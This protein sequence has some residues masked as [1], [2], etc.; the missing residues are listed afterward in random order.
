MASRLLFVD[1]EDQYF[2]THRLAPARAA[3]ARGYEVHVAT[4]LG[5]G[6]DAIEAEGFVPHA[7]SSVRGGLS[8]T[9][10]LAAISELRAVLRELKPDLMH[11]IGVQNVVLGG[12]AAL[13]QG[14]AVVNSVTGL[15]TIVIP[16][17]MPVPMRKGITLA[18]QWLLNRRGSR[19]IVQ[20]P[21]DLFPRLVQ[22]NHRLGVRTSPLLKRRVLAWVTGA[23]RTSAAY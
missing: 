14:V 17:R 9:A 16:G 2:L 22:W 23:R 10:S 11:N 21:D 4:R 20:N 3:A 13:G 1:T 18:L 15:G 12:S 8:P 19:T 6:R 5:E 7:L